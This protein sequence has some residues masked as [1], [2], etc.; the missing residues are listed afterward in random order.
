MIRKGALN[1][2]FQVLLAMLLLSACGDSVNHGGK[3]PYIGVGDEYLYKEDLEQAYMANH[4]QKDSA[5]FMQE[6]IEHWLEDAL[7]YSRAKHNVSS[8]KE[9]ARLIESYKKSL[10]L[11]IYQERLVDQQ[12]DKEITAEEIA[13]FYEANSAM[14]KME[15]PM[16]KGLLLKVSKKAPKLDAV[17]RWCKST[18][19]AEL[20]KLEKYTLT[21]AQL[22]EYFYDSWMPISALAAKIALSEEDLKQKVTK[23]DM[24]EFSDSASLYI[25]NISDYLPVGEL[26]PLDLAESEI[27][28]LLVNSRKADFLQQVKKDIYNEA[29]SGGKVKYFMN[30]PE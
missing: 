7:L 8:S 6:Y 2:V 18:E 16:I 4:T 17:R 29:I 5:A 21:N 22:Y 20:E 14:F 3:T 26:K 1:T 24:I 19:P 27:K 11:N 23:K 9:I 13:S 12:L 30:K 10:L 15:E 28:E 25:M